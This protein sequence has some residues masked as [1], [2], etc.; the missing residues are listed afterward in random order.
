MFSRQ[1]CQADLHRQG[2]QAE[3]PGRVAWQVCQAELPG[4]VARQGFQAALPDIYICV[5]SE[6]NLPKNEDFIYNI[7]VPFR[8]F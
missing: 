5:K 4:R 3:L 8:A 2:C 6:E 1:G 7:F